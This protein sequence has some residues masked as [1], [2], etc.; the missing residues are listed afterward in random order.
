M[1][2]RARRPR[3]ATGRSLGSLCNKYLTNAP[4]HQ[5]FMLSSRFCAVILGRRGRRLRRFSLHSDRAASA[6]PA[7]RTAQFLRRANRIGCAALQSEKRPR[8]KPRASNNAARGF[9]NVNRDAERISF[10]R[11]PQ[12]LYP[13]EARHLAPQGRLWLPS[14]QPDARL[15]AQCRPTRPGLRLKARR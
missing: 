1:W 10:R 8:K 9:E 13:L 15:A 11:H 7:W 6:Q 14:L 4:G 12:H 2:K 5:L 3:F